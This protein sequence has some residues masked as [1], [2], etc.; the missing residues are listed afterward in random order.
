M[1]HSVLIGLHAAAGVICFAAGLLCIPLRAPGSW[2]FRVYAGSL[3]AMLG[4]VIGS[5]AYSWVGLSVTTR[6]IFTC[7]AGLGLYMVWRASRAYLRLRR[8]AAGWQPKYLDD[9]GF[10]LIS[11][12]DG[13][14]IVGAID[15][16][17]PVWPVVLAAVTGVV[18]GVQAMEWVKTKLVARGPA[19]PATVASDTRPRAT[20]GVETSRNQ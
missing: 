8:Q 19:I 14:V 12:L 17:M 13:F 20:A 16:G 18:I 4:F 10:T 2:R 11:L 5:I 15:L 7:L 1:L 3:L 9:I 6:L